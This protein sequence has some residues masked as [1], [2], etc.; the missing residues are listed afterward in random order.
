MTGDGLHAQGL[1][2]GARKASGSP[3]PVELPGNSLTRRC[4]V[5]LSPRPCVRHSGPSDTHL[6]DTDSRRLAWSWLTE[7]THTGG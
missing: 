5:T 7:G 4:L 6:L 1:C 3:N 2:F